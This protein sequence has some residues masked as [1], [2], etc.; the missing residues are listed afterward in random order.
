MPFSSAWE[1]CSRNRSKICAF[2]LVSIALP[3]SAVILTQ[4]SWVLLYVPIT[5]ITIST[6]IYNLSV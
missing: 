4:Y 2:P 6:A 3:F 5:E 1:K